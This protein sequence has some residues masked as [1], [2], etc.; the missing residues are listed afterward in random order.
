[1]ADVHS[2]LA[3]INRRLTAS[4]ARVRAFVDRLTDRVDQLVDAAGQGKWPELNRLSKSLAYRAE[5]HGFSDLADA[6]RAVS[7]AFVRTD[8]QTEVH[9]R[10]TGLVSHCGRVRRRGRDNALKDPLD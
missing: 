2:D 8:G 10:V 6:A 5:L 3:E 4:N 1:M 7:D 9:R